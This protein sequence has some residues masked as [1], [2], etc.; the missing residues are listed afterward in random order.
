[1][2]NSNLIS[3]GVEWYKTLSLDQK[4]GLKETAHLLT[5]M[6]WEQFPLLVSPRQR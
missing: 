3:T 6:R 1:M 5:G 2:K 4:F